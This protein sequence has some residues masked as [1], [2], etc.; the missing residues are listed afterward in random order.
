MS[1]VLIVFVLAAVALP[2]LA[3]GAVLQAERARV[4]IRVERRRH[5]SR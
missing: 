1:I 3:A 2:A 4:Q 5:P